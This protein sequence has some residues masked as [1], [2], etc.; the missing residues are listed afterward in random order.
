[1][2]LAAA[3]GAWLV[4]SAVVILLRNGVWRDDATLFLAEAQRRPPSVRMLAAAA[5]VHGDQ[6]RPELAIARLR[7]A[8][9]LAPEDAVAWG[10]LGAFLLQVED[11]AQAEPALRRSLVARYGD[12]KS[13]AR[14]H[15]NL[16]GLL[17]RTARADEAWSHL[18]KG[19]EVGHGDNSLVFVL[20]AL[21]LAPGRLPEPEIED[22][23]ALARRMLPLEAE[24]VAVK[25]ALLDHHRGL[26]LLRRGLL[27]QAQAHL[28]RAW[29]AGGF[30]QTGLALGDVLARL[31]QRDAAR[32]LYLQLARNPACSAAVREE[33][34]RRAGGL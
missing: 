1:M 10:N 26:Q 14:A 17:S 18:L 33:A 12:A 20:D 16:G 25:G 3:L 4:A 6:G 34:G 8:V 13:R 28:Q 27:P 31:G 22:L 7:E 5:K 15:G 2:A 24:D 32:A 23:L 21:E 29:Q 11:H 30:E 19:L 9:A